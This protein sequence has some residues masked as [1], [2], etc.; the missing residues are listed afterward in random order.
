VFISSG[1]ECASARP[2]LSK[3][4]HRSRVSHSLS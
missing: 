1:I 4:V 3:M 2:E